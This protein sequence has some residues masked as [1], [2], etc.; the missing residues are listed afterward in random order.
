VVETYFDDDVESCKLKADVNLCR[1]EDLVM[2]ISN[3]DNN[4]EGPQDKDL[5]LSQL[6]PLV[7]Q[8]NVQS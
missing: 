4:K 7:A 2:T 3:D 8:D 6:P 5:H 1:V